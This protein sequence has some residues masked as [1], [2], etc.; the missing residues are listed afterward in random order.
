[1]KIF[2]M[3]VATAF[4]SMSLGIPRTSGALTVSSMS[5]LFAGRNIYAPTVIYDEQEGVYKMWYGGWQS[6][7]DA[8]NDRIYYRY[9]FDSV[10]WSVP[11]TV[12]SP[13]GVHYAGVH[14]ND[15][16]VTKTYNEITNAWQ[17]TIF[18][19]LCY[20][21]CSDAESEIWSAVSGDGVN[22]YYHQSVLPNGATN[23]SVIYEP[24]TNGA[25]W[26]LYYINRVEGAQEVKMVQVDGLRFAITTPISVFQP[27]S[28]T[29]GDLEVRQ[30][31]GVWTLFYNKMGATNVDLYF[32][33][34]LDNASFPSSSP[35][36]VTAGSPHFCAALTP[37]VL[38]LSGGSYK[39][40]FS[41]TEMPLNNQ[42][43]CDLQNRTQAIQL[44][45]ITP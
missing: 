31:A 18:Y 14:A 35:F 6:S 40:F 43:N 41:L 4:I 17:Y 37:G 22:W 19:T 11:T 27:A 3:F 30:I 28:T 23:P 5:T 42:G 16:S 24:D 10:N 29:V 36:I 21:G 33:E 8:P 32:A 38:P 44:W 26:K 1:M 45:D 12:I 25:V 7:Y 20:G 39:L 13:F 9:S 15:P 2:R 34:S